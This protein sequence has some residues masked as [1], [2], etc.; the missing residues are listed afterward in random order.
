MKKIILGFLLMASLIACSA[1]PIFASVPVDPAYAGLSITDTNTS[2]SKCRAVWVGTSQSIDFYINGAWVTFQGASAGSIIP[3]QATGA[4][5]TSGS[6]APA[7]G[8]IVFLY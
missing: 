8:D 7:A 5:I 4:R 3:I 2:H 1:N 6:T